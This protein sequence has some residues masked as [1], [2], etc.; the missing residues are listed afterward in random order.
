VSTPGG[1]V[2][3]LYSFNRNDG[4]APV[5]ELIVGADGNL[6]GTTSG[7]HTGLAA[8]T[9]GCG[10]AFMITTNGVLT[11]LHT[12]GGSDGREP[13]GRLV[14]DSS[15][16]LYGT[17][18]AGGA[19]FFGTVFQVTTNG[20]FTRLLSFNGANG[21]N[22]LA[23]LVQ[24]ADGAFYGTTSVGGTLGGYGTVF[25]L[26]ISTNAG[27]A[28]CVLS[29]LVTTNNIGATNTLIAT[30]TSNGVAR[31]GVAVTFTVTT[32]PNSGQS[33]IVVTGA[34]GQASFSYRGS[35]TP[36]T[37]TIRATSLGASG[38]ATAIWVASDSV[39]DGI[40]D[41]WRAQYFGGDGTT[42]NSQSCAMCDADGT[43]QNNLF[44]YVAGLNPTNATSVFVLS[45]SNVTGQ[46]THRN[47][48]Y[49]PIAPGRTYSLQYTID[50]SSGWAALTG[51]GSPITNQNQVT[52][53]DLDATQPIKFYRIGISYP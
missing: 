16:M 22:P 11:T 14:Q 43:G 51:T 50:L 44:K 24:G 1:V 34:G 19:S 9:N 15:G 6:Y 4:S 33:R 17:T 29:P 46:P 23:G 35:M 52:V 26:R 2:T 32:G 47:L 36:G 10:T 41:W 53:T 27:S 25:K 31:V 40:P 21:G 28:S 48:I 3:T 8:C 39:G 20:D 49:G 42:T 12:F 38:T 18:S 7:G 45:A 5:A 30:V 13:R 37:D